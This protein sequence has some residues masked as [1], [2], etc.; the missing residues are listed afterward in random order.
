MIKSPAAFLVDPSGKI[1]T[2]DAFGRL[3]VSEPHT[4]IDL[5][6][7]WNN[8][9][10]FIAEETSG[11]GQNTYLQREAAVIMTTPAVAG[12]TALRQTKRYFNYQTGKSQLIM[13]TFNLEGNDEGNIK[14]AGYGDDNNGLFVQIDGTDAGTYNLVRRSSV[15][16]VVVEEKVAQSDWNLDKF[17]GT[18]PSGTVLDLSKVQILFIDFQW[19]GVGSVRMGF[20]IDGVGYF[21][22]Q[23]NHAN[24]INSVFMQT[25]NLPVRWRIENVDGVAPGTMKQICCTVIT[26][27]GLE[28]T[29]VQ[30]SIGNGTFGSPK[31]IGTGAWTPVVSIR[32]KEEFIRSTVIPKRAEIM[33]T[34]GGNLYWEI[35]LNPTITGGAAPFWQSLDPLSRVEGDINQNG[36]VAGGS[37]IASGY[38]SADADYRTIEIDSVLNIAATIDGVSDILTMTAISYSGNETVYGGFTWLEV[39]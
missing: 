4:L 25:P 17:D 19:L 29:G 12:A 35:V 26:E 9:P 18:G 28:E 34:T 10:R 21:A 6:M 39:L 24:V 3:R 7:P 32:L 23:F 20:V 1:N 31:T 16:G 14:E 15:S 2:F 37:L 5:K 33:C 22:H 13:M 11:G 27:G 30:Q 36:N 8:L 38:I